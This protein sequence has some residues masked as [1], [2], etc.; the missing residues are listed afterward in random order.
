MPPIIY[1]AVWTMRDGKRMPTLTSLAT[2]LDW[3]K[4]PEGY[5]RK[6]LER[7]NRRSLAPTRAARARHTATSFVV[8]KYVPASS[9]GSAKFAEAGSTISV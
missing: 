7:Y 8:E 9:F 5:S 3:N 1:V 6:R 2:Y 4:D